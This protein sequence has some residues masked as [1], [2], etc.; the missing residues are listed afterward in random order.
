MPLPPGVYRADH[1]GSF[2]R[3]VDVKE[4]RKQYSE[5][6]INASQLRAVEDQVTL[7]RILYQFIAIIT[8]LFSLSA[9]SSKIN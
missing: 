6:K 7:L 2:L 9:Q 4:A 1:V 8:F 3:P 5:G